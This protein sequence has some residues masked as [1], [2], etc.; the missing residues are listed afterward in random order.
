MAVFDCDK[1]MMM[2]VFDD[3]LYYIDFFGYN[4]CL[5]N[6]HLYIIIIESN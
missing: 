6:Y 1:A 4:T 2:T 5:L 3:S